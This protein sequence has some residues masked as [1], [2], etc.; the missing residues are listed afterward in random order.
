VTNK[1]E[2]E[3]YLQGKKKAKSDQRSMEEASNKPDRADLLGGIPNQKSPLWTWDPYVWTIK[4]IYKT[5]NAR[6]GREFKL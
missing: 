5:G 3:T 1:G 4:N 2:K 6:S